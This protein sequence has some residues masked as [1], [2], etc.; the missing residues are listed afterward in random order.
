V[1]PDLNRRHFLGGAA[2]ALAAGGAHLASAGSDPPQPIRGDEG[3]TILGPQNRPLQ[4]QNPDAL[5]PPSTDAGNLPNLKFSFSDANTRLTKGGWARQVTVEELPIATTMAGVDMRLKPGAIRE[6]HWHNT[7][8]WAIMLAGNARVTLVDTEGRNFIGDVGKEDLWFFPAGL[9]HSIQALDQGCE[10]L[11]VFDDG[12]FSE[13]DTFL[14]CD[15]FTHTPTEVLAKNFGVP[16]SA[17]A[18]IPPDLEQQRYIFPAAVPGSLSSQTVSS[19]YGTI[20]HSA[21]YRLSQQK[22]VECPGG[23][24][25]VA[26]SSNFPITNIA[27]GLV[28]IDPGAMR[29]LHWH[30]NADEW[31][32]YIS[33]QGRMTVFAANGVANTFDYQ[34]GDVGYVPRPMGHYIENTGSSPV[35]FLEMFANPHFE[36]VSLDQWMALIPRELLRA[37]LPLDNRTLDALSKQQRLVVR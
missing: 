8:E 27:A 16:E 29:E 11:L 31:Q 20:P 6:L 33:G 25:K 19:P 30:P 32:F 18:N 9:P 2:V 26:D 1:T 22:A 5:A 15:W 7:D 36:S 3:A 34:A 21:T 13:F 37:H 12:H 4:S 28:E 24:V 23:R 10:F 14:I 35:R 17:F